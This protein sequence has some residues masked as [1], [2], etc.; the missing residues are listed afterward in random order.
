MA[1]K[2]L[3]SVVSPDASVVEESVESIVAPGVEGYF[4][5]FAGHE[6]T[7]FALKPGLVEYPDGSTNRHYVY[8]GGGFAEVQPDRVTIIADEAERAPEIDIARAE[9][10]LEEARKALR[11]EDST[12]DSQDA[13]LEVERAM[14]RI[15]AARAAR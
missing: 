10:H 3:L 4:G 11:G 8:I 13:V 5:V 6:P 15:K 12:I 1:T 9:A 14:S 2:F 7:I